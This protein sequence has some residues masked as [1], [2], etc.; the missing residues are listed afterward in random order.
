MKPSVTD[1][2]MLG[3]QYRTALLDDVLPFWEKHS[4]DTRDGGFFSC[5]ARDGSV[6]DTDKFIWPQCR[7][8]WLYSMLF[9]RLERPGEVARDGGPRGQVPPGPREGPGRELVFRPDA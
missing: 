4:L 7:Q 1:F 3:R 2:R 5:L 8:V 6:Y 9:N